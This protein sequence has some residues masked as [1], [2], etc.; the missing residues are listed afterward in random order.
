MMRL[1]QGFWLITRMDKPIGIYLLLWPTL[2]AVVLA[3]LG[4]PQLDVFVIFAAGVVVMRAAGCVINDIADRKVDG[5][6]TRTNARPLVSGLLSTKE[7][8]IMFIGL[9]FI[10]LVL[11][12]QL[13]L[14][15]FYL[16]LVALVLASSYP[17][18]KRYTHLPQVVL[19]AAFSWSIPMAFMAI[20]QNIPHWAWYLYVANL[21][22]TVAYDTLY[23]MV[24]RDDDLK[25]GV[26]STAILFGRHDLT[27]VGLLYGVMLGFLALLGY[28]LILGTWYFAGL[29]V[30]AGFIGYVMWQVRERDLTQC[31]AMFKANHWIGLI[32]LLGLWAELLGV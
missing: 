24:D 7:A 32:F 9:L 25:I 15:T 8:I 14:A 23:A 31:F 6:V 27:M 2:W 1:L 22:W 28:E 3:S 4:Q 20:N 30:M 21:A 26:K 10:A 5:H 12:L 16:S 11:V 17:F 29:S 19:G 13:N 18:M